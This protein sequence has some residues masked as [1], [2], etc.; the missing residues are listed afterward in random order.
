MYVCLYMHVCMYVCIYVYVCVCVCVCV[1]VLN[2]Q[3]RTRDCMRLF[4]NSEQFNA[5]F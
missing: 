2:R 3:V 5:G 4:L 1:C